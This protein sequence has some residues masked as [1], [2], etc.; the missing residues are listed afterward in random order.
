MKALRQYLEE[1][2]ALRRSLGF[3][4]NRQAHRLDRFVSFMEQRHA[5]RIST[6]LAIEWAM[7]AGGPAERGIRLTAVRGFARH[8][9]GIDPRTDIPPAGLIRYRM[10]AT[11]YLYSAEEI[12]CILSACDTLTGR[13]ARVRGQTLKC[14]VGLIAA[15]GL[16][17]SEA[18][19]LRCEDID[20]KNGLLTIRGTKFGKSRL[21][22]IHATTTQVLAE[23]ARMRDARLPNRPTSHFFVGSRGRRIYLQHLHVMF[24]DLLRRAGIWVGTARGRPRL[25]DL[26]HRF[27]VETLLRWYRSGEDVAARMQTLSTYLGHCETRDTYWYL[28]AAPE[29]LREAARRLVRHPVEVAS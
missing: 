14:L 26:R 12:Q 5:A 24:A 28:S 17:S 15:T 25:H 6:A 3:K 27:A 23:Y 11:P 1:Y 21:V 9:S 19:S 2:V 13:N 10:R 29:L 8:L 16:R 7:A 4:F 20:L 22:P 18:L